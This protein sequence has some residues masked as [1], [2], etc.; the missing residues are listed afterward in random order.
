MKAILITIKA[1]HL[2]NIL[3]GKKI[4]ELRKSFPKLK[5]PFKVYCCESASG[6][7]IK[8][9]FTC[10]GRRV[11]EAFPCMIE[12]EACVTTE[13][14]FEYF[15]HDFK[16]AYGWIIKNPVT[17][18]NLNIKDFGLNRAPQSWCYVEDT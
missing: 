12:K 13:E 10:A 18:E 7:Q 11:V 6:G 4:L 2:N 16:N 5:P 15:K 3:T 9:C 8:G 17:L 1:R 14:M